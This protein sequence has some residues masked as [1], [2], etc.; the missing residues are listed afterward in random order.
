MPSRKVYMTFLG[1]NQY[2]KTS[3]KWTIGNTTFES[4]YGQEAELVM[5]KEH[6]EYTPDVVYVLATETAEQ[7]NWKE[8]RGFRYENDQPVLSDNK[9]PGLE[10][11]L[12]ACLPTTTTIKL[13][14]IQNGLEANSQWTIFETLIEHI[15]QHDELV[16]DIT[17]GY[18]VTPVI[19]SSAL[20][21]LRLT[22][23]VTIKH[24]YYAA[25]ETSDKRIIDYVGFYDI[26]DLTE[27]VAR[28]NDEADM[29]KLLALSQKGRFPVDLSPLRK[30]NLFKDLERLTN[31]V[32]NVES[33]IV[34]KNAKSAM[35]SL[36][37]QLNKAQKHG[38]TIPTLLLNKI[39]EKFAKLAY[40]QHQ[41]LFDQDYF[42]VQQE[43]IHTL[44][45]HQL[46]MQ[47][48]TVLRE[49]VG[50]LGMIFINGS[51][52]KLTK[53]RKDRYLI[54]E[55]FLGMI[56]FADKFKRTESNS[57]KYA[58][59]KPHYEKLI[60]QGIG[61]RLQTLMVLENKN[62]QH[63]HPGINKYRTAFAH[64]CTKQL[65]VPDGWQE[66]ATYWLDELTQITAEI[67]KQQEADT[68]G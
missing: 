59:L 49:Y 51:N 56:Q 4:P 39:K 26:Q 40:R 41:Q 14:R 8:W 13:I 38:K 6:T 5:A 3:Y 35:D 30:G 50:T 57:D 12:R 62:R 20:H 9:G 63:K 55:T 45:D 68:N 61:Q 29:R 42:R 11:R 22:K 66:A 58:V 21:F 24:V 53:G 37:V 28:L 46:F 2:K 33:H 15:Q 10:P 47:A 64:A 65:H 16:I 48:Y 31:S 36:T 19:L 34:G 67:F 25:F 52:W 7:A 44:I 54:G 1:T 43:L 23:D 18:R 17:H 32:R 27:G 60:E